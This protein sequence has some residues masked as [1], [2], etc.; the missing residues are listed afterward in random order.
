MQ[1]LLH[2]HGVQV[3][4]AISVTLELP[5]GLEAKEGPAW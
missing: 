5:V 4:T 1:E 2:R 3:A